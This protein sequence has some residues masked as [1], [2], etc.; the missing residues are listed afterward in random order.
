L[1]ERSAARHVVAR[2]TRWCHAELTRH[3][4]RRAVATRAA[5]PEQTA[6]PKRSPLRT[7]RKDDAAGNVVVQGF[8]D[9]S[10]QRGCDPSANAIDPQ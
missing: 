2:R 8:D 10:P 6:R 3:R 4:D 7:E 1:A 9:S 5:A